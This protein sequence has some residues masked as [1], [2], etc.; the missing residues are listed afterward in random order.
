MK[1]DNTQDMEQALQDFFRSM[2]LEDGYLET[3]IRLRWEEMVGRDIA[4]H[5]HQINYKQGCLKLK[6]NSSTLR[7]EL[8]FHRAE[9]LEQ[10]NYRL[11]TRPVRELLIR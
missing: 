2:G 7:Q 6:L 9:L 3:E 5:T 10:I 11:K 1:K 8:M 4:H